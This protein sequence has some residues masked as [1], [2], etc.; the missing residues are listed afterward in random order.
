MSDEIK[1]LE[2]ALADL[3]TATAEAK[4]QKGLKLPTFAKARAAILDELEAMGWDLKRDLKVPHATSPDGELR[5]WFK[6]QAVWFTQS[7]GSYQRHDFKNARTIDY[8]HDI[9][10][11]TAAELI[12]RARR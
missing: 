1:K 5:L 11:M 8:V 7:L 9:R 10:K 2:R 4:R 12:E 3:N 6:P